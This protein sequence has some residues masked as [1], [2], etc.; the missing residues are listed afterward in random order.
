MCRRWSGRG[1]LITYITTNGSIQSKAKTK[2]NKIDR[3]MKNNDLRKSKNEKRL[4]VS[5]Q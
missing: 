5:N 3:P 1:R 2:G 4:D